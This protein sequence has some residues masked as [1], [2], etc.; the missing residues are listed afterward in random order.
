MLVVFSESSREDLAQSLGIAT[1]YNE[2]RNED[3]DYCIRRERAQEILACRALKIPYV[4]VAEPSFLGD[5]ADEPILDTNCELAAL[6]P[7]T[8]LVLRLY[9]DASLPDKLRVFPLLVSSGHERQ[10]EQWPNH[11]VSPEFFLKRQVIQMSQALFSASFHSG[12]LVTPLFLKSTKKSVLHHVVGSSLELNG[13]IK[14][15]GVITRDFPSL[16]GQV[17]KLPAE[18]V[19]A[20]HKYPDYDCPYRGPVKGHFKVIDLSEGVII[21]SVMNILREPDHRGEYRAFIVNGEVSSMS[22]YRDYDHSPVPNEVSQF[23]HAFAEQHRHV[24]PAYVADFCLTDQG[25]ALVELNGL[26]YAGRYVDNDPG[27]LYCD[28]ERFAGVDRSVLCDP[29]VAVPS[30]AETHMPETDDVVVDFGEPALP[31]GL[32]GIDRPEPELN[33]ASDTALVQR[34]KNALVDKESHREDD[35]PAADYFKLG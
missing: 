26:A 11:I 14:P 4:V 13:L 20:L 24:A 1:W 9:G 18:Q 8:P 35:Q 23:A 16:A 19:V 2:F 6:D 17:N 33:H 21:S 15:A 28:L 7:S 12:D 30:K 29:R 5:E 31:W 32:S 10:V 25:P 22:A 3:L 34:F 27:L